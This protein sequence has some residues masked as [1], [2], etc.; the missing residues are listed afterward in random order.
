LFCVFLMAVRISFLFTNLL[1]HI[2]SI[3]YAKRDVRF[4]FLTAVR[5]CFVF[6]N[7]LLRIGNINYA[8]REDV[9]FLLLMAVKICLEF[10]ISCVDY[11][12][13]QQE[14][15]L[16]CCDVVLLFCLFPWMNFLCL[17]ALQVAMEFSI[18]FYVPTP[19]VN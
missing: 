3:N 17:L 19:L 10:G 1:L 7:L 16:P 12:H 4:E 9:R 8:R 11:D 5:I 14:S 13:P 2:R 15:C 18:V 6:A